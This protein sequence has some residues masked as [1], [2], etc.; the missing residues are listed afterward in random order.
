MQRGEKD[1]RK[2]NKRKGR[3]ERKEKEWNR[4]DI[5]RDHS[6]PG[7]TQRVIVSM[8]ALLFYLAGVVMEVHKSRRAS[9]W[10]QGRK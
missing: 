1:K 4:Q 9:P 6:V 10:S 2:K 5:P 3:A 8:K 7:L